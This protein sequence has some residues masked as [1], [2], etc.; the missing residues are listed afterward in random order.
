MNSKK[1]SDAMSEIDDTYIEEAI[2]YQKKTWKHSQ[3]KWSAIAA[4]FVVVSV[5]A[6]SIVAHY[7]NQQGVT[8]PD[9]PKGIIADN[10]NAGTPPTASEIHISMDNIFLNDIAALSDAALK[11]YDPEL[12]DSVLWDK[13]TVINYYGKDLTPVYIPDGLIAASLNGSAAV[14][15]D[16]DGS[17]VMD[18]VWLNFYHEYYED[19]SPKLTED[20]AACKGFSITASKVGLLQDC[21]YLLPENEIKTSDIGG[22][23]VTFGY[24]SMPYGPFAP[25]TH[26][27]SG[28]YDMYIAEF[29]HDSIEY[30][31]VADQ[32]E[33]KELVKV[34]TAVITGEN[35]IVIDESS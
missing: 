9:N 32:M 35:K 17:I 34:V 20:V 15:A 8:P 25:K 12:Y 13:E 33:L 16:K 1:F 31:I 29:E 27:P 28:Y 2:H 10:P 11:W 18:T 26:E 7:L 23:S 6:F 19:G 4:C 30:Q 14:I 22:T 24:R 21:I 5:A 3:T